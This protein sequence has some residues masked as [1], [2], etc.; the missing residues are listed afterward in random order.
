LPERGGAQRERR[1]EKEGRERG[2]GGGGE[3]QTEGET[4]LQRTIKLPGGSQ[5]YG[6]YGQRKPRTMIP[7]RF[8]QAPYGLRTMSITMRNFALE[9]A[10]ATASSL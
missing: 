4:L 7:I 10:S 5:A 2:G 6:A 1:G 9:A 3:R 8:Q